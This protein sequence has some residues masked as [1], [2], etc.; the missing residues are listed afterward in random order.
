MHISYSLLTEIQL[1]VRLVF[2]IDPNH[3]YICIYR[4]VRAVIYYW[5]DDFTNIH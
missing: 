5:S 4:Y 1:H 2:F 3:K